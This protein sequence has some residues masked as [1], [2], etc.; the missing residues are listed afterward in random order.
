MEV[1][2]NYRNPRTNSFVWTGTVLCV[3][4]KSYCEK[5]ARDARLQVTEAN[6]QVNFVPV[7]NRSDPDLTVYE[8]I[9]QVLMNDDQEVQRA[10]KKIK[11]S[12]S[13]QVTE[14]TSTTQNPE[15]DDNGSSQPYMTLNPDEV[16]AVLERMSNS[17][18]TVVPDAEVIEEDNASAESENVHKTPNDNSF[19]LPASSST[20]ANK[21][22][23]KTKAVNHEEI[24]ELETRRADLRVS[25]AILEAANKISNAAEMIVNCMQELKP[26]LRSLAN[27]NYREI[28]M[29]S[30][31]VKQ[32]VS[33]FL[34]RG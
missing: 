3:E 12:M 9:N 7:V 10:K 21:K 26:E 1:R 25:Q 17:S 22:M 28:Q 30:N 33:C 6:G 11:F 15:N 29:S 23:R 34:S 8:D 27:R 5:E 4:H 32:L 2:Y 18:R 16:S 24:A 20:P 19:E 13:S 31:A 14:N